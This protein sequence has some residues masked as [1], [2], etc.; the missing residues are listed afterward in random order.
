LTRRAPCDCFQY[1]NI[2]EEHTN[3]FKAIFEC[4]KDPGNAGKLKNLVDVTVHHFTD[5]EGMMEKVKYSD[6]ASHKQ[7]HSEF[8]KTIQGLSTPLSDEVVSFAKKWLVNHIKGVDFK[9]K[10]KL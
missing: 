8:V 6:L 4:S 2:D 10:G 7:I 3:I 1:D 5:E 9:Y